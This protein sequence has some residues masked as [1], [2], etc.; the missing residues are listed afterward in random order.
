MK[1]KK[2]RSEFE[3]TNTVVECLDKK[4]AE[5]VTFRTMSDNTFYVEFG[6]TG[7][8]FKIVVSRVRAARHEY[9][10]E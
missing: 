6:D 4:I 5:S 3:M 1:M 7:E 2:T 9:G 8:E 10:A